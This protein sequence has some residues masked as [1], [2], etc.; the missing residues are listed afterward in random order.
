MEVKILFSEKKFKTLDGFIGG[1]DVTEKW[2][3]KLWDETKKSFHT[4]C[5]IF[6]HLFKRYLLWGSYVPGTILSSDDTSVNKLHAFMEPAFYLGLKAMD[7]K[8]TQIN[9]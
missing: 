6:I 1:V 4:K 8:Q 9:I 2:N 3:S 5:L 7:S